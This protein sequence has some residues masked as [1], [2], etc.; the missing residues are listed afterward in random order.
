MGTQRYVNSKN[1]NKNNFQKMA[2]TNRRKRERKTLQE[3]R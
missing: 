2:K 1:K 3:P